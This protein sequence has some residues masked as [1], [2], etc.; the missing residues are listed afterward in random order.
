MPASQRHPISIATSE[1][2]LKTPLMC[3]TSNWV[4]R[5]GALLRT[6][7]TGSS[8]TSRPG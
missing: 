3:S 1:G 5:T 7:A 8:F 4:P 6:S 2:R